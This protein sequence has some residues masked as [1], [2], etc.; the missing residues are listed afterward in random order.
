MK[1]KEGKT[2]ST[3]MGRDNN[4]DSV[5]NDER[6]FAKC[7]RLKRLGKHTYSQLAISDRRSGR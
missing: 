6:F 2:Y 4:N 1:K 7:T 3:K 5:D